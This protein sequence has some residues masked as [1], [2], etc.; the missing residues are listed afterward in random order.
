V[1]ESVANE[2]TRT[3]SSAN[4]PS[5]RAKVVDSGVDSLIGMLERQP[6]NR[7]TQSTCTDRDQLQRRL[8]STTSS[9][10]RLELGVSPK[11]F[12]NIQRGGKKNNNEKVIGTA[13]GGLQGKRGSCCHLSPLSLQLDA[14]NGCHQETSLIACIGRLGVTTH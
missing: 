5:K 9:S 4:K 14:S 12:R 10:Q 1:H 3:T 2:E 7:P 8:V 13:Y 11:H 6:S